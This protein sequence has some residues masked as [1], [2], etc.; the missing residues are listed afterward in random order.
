MSYLVSSH[1]YNA[2]I[3][4]RAQSRKKEQS[5]DARSVL[6]GSLHIV[7]TPGRPFTLVRPVICWRWDVED[8]VGAVEIETCA[9]SNVTF[10]GFEVGVLGKIGG[11]LQWISVYGAD[12]GLAFCLQKPAD[13]FSAGLGGGR[14]D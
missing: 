12:Q 5:L 2:M 9:C 11:S 10:G 13:C 4:L 3:M 8:R 7:R 6:D 14:Y 1:T